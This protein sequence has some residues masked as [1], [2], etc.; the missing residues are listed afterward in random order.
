MKITTRLRFAVVAALMGATLTA[1]DD[2]TAPV[3][4][5]DPEVTAAAMA[6]MVAASE[7]M[8][9]AWVGMALAGGL[10]EN[11]SSASLLPGG[12][13]ILLDA[14]ATRDY[15]DRFG[16]RAFFPS[17]YLGVTF[18]WNQGQ[19]GYVASEETGAPEDGIRV[20]YYAVN[21]TNGRPSNPLTPLGYID[22]RDLSTAASD[23][24]GVTVEQTGD[25]AAT[26]ADYFI[27]LSYSSTQD[28]T[29]VEQ[30]SEGY[31]SNG[32]DRLDFDLANVVTITETTLT[33]DQSYEMSLAGTDVRV[34]YDG[35]LSGD[36]AGESTTLS[37]DATITGS[38]TTVRF[39]I[40]S[41]GELVDGGVYHGSVLVAT[42]SGSADHPVFTSAATGEELTAAQLEAL[43]DVFSAVEGLF[44]LAG[45]IFGITE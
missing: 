42:I 22:L 39:E 28:E 33:L 24:L 15:A 26:L 23:R 13:T 3:G 4:T 8:E 36:W 41:D 18:V 6:D 21:P 9:E 30:V 35:A 37:I 17:N 25:A 11:T 34:S 7:D 10:F 44:E 14:V 40:A 12:G 31:L 45:G 5:F 29:V 32:S 2:A 27:D 19:Q 16:T 20:I 38:G 1:C 43:A